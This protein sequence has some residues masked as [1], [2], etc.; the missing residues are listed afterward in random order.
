MDDLAGKEGV[1]PT[2]LNGREY[3]QLVEDRQKNPEQH[4]D[5]VITNDACQALVDI[6]VALVNSSPHKEYV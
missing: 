6:F 5:N 1:P 4:E 2:M 3:A